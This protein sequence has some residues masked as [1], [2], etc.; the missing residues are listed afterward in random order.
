MWPDSAAQL[1]ARASADAVGQPLSALVDIRQREA[2]SNVVA[3]VFRDG[4]GG[5]VHTMEL[6]AERGDGLT[7]PAECSLWYCPGDPGGTSRCNVL[8]RSI[9]TRVCMEDALRQE[10]RELRQLSA[11]RIEELRRTQARFVDLVETI[12]EVFWMADAGI[13][14]MLYISPGY[15]RVWGRTCQSLYDDPRSFMEAVHPDDR[16]RIVHDLLQRT[17]QPFEHEYRIVRPDGRV[18]WVS[19]RGFPVLNDD[20]S[21]DR[22]LGVAQDISARKALELERRRQEATDAI[23]Q[24]ASGLAN[25]FSN[26]LGLVVGH[27]DL[28]AFALPGDSMARESI[29]AALTAALDGVRLAQRLQSV[30]RPVPSTPRPLDVAEA[31]D[32]LRSLL[33]HASGSEVAVPVT[34]VR[35]ATVIVDPVAFDAAFITLAMHARQGLVGGGRLTVTLDEVAVP[36][37]ADPDVPGGR[38]ASVVVDV[39]GPHAADLLAVGSPGAERAPAGD[40]AAHLCAYLRDAGGVLRV[41]RSPEGGCRF[42]AFLPSAPTE[43]EP[44]EMVEPSWVRAVRDDLLDSRDN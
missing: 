37:Q 41:E 7:F 27:L 15:E 14:R 19:D 42:H 9:S 34:V 21:I 40:G 43:S 16:A 23:A 4:G 33:R 8:V 5:G 44:A 18:R 3:H 25:D 12:D 10:L 26:T 39:D 38:Y 13:T 1:F 36:A 22:Y 29:D 11:E 30:G 32:G 35:R 17:G 6:V 2:C 28:A 20:G 24:M 31:V